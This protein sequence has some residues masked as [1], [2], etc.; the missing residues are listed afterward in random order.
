MAAQ[1]PDALALKSWEDAFQHPLP[2]VR[3]LE[4]QLRQHIDDN[5]QK[6]RSLVG[7]SYRDLLGTAED[8]I[9]MGEEMQRVERNL[10]DIGM[11]CNAKAVERIVASDSRMQKNRTARDEDYHQ[12]MAQTRVLQSA[13]TAVSRIIKR[14]GDAFQ[15]AKLLLLSR[16]L[17]KSVSGVSRPPLVLDSLRAK[18][19]S[20]RAKLLSHI[21]R[22][23]SQQADSFGTLSQA[24]WAYALITSSTQK[25]VLR[26]F[27]QSRL[28]RINAES[29]SLPSGDILTALGVY[30]HTLLEVRD[31][32]PRRFAEA[33]AQLTK[34]PL[35]QDEQ[36]RAV[37]EL[38]LE[39]YGDWIAGDIQ[40]FTPWIRHDQLTSAELSDAFA[41]WK[42]DAQLALLQHLRS[43]INLEE[44]ASVVVDV[45]YKVLSRV[46][47]LSS[48]V[49]SEDH[50]SFI[51]DCRSVFLERLTELATH[52]AALS[53]LE[54][55]DATI[56]KTVDDDLAESPLWAMARR[57]VDLSRGAIK[58]RAALLQR[59]YGRTGSMQS[60]IEELDAWTTRIE[61]LSTTIANMRSIIWDQDLDADINNLDNEEMLRESLNKQD[62]DQLLQGLSADVTNALSGVTEHITNAAITA[63]HPVYYLRL[64]REIERR[65]RILQSHLSILL[66]DMSLTPLHEKIARLTCGTSLPRYVQS[67]DRLQYVAVALWDGSPPLPV[68]PS[69]STF[70]FLTETHKAMSDAGSDVWTPQCVMELK[71]ILADELSSQLSHLSFAKPESEGPLTNGHRQSDTQTADNDKEG[72]RPDSGIAQEHE[73]QSA[74]QKLWD[75]HYLRRIL[76]TSQSIPDRLL[77]RIQNMKTHWDVDDAADQRLRKTA[78]EYWKRTYLLFGLLAVGSDDAKR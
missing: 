37:T 57:E 16:L 8:I 15:A 52:A 55:D 67:S 51:Q 27:L 9:G 45:R 62:P 35:L 41:S 61:V 20:L 75:L 78:D 46:L 33:L 2:V 56:A 42:S 22:T 77:E 71:S 13:L 18:L 70:R 36:I 21:D 23:I 34:T 58:F 50:V 32:F 28:R 66:P 64:W 24:L 63:N 1:A 47:S 17:H 7:A 74:L 25:E 31:L 76:H 43:D 48:K 11:K 5:R 3:S 72:T 39:I 10:T 60:K 54:L 19:S 68:Q 4:R 14:H 53:S 6:L 12:A 49:S 73:R 30:S 38:N 40:A 44:N 65:V 29:D 69:P 26:H 59:H